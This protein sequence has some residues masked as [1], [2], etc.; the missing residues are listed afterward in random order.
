MGELDSIAQSR[1]EKTPMSYAAQV[2]VNRAG[3]LVLA[4]ILLSILVAI[5]FCAL[6]LILPL[7]QWTVG[8]V[9]I[10]IAAGGAVTLLI[11]WAKYPEARPWIMDG[12]AA[13]LGLTSATLGIAITLLIAY[14]LNLQISEHIG[15]RNNFVYQ[16]TSP[17]ILWQV[18]Y[19][20]LVPAVP[21]AVGHWIVRRRRR[22]VAGAYHWRAWPPGSRRSDCGFRR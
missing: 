3:K 16:M 9:P 15:S 21:G 5:L 1:R 18:V 6:S 11:A 17:M 7:H 22:E 4:V 13:V 12:L 19:F 14:G 10:R 8:R 2:V 20:A